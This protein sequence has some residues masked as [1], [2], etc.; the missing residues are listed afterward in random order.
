MQKLNSSL[1]MYLPP[2]RCF[3]QFPYLLFLKRLDD[4]ENATKQ[5]VEGNGQFRA[6]GK[7]NLRAW[8]RGR[9]IEPVEVSSFCMCGAHRLE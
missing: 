6:G 5:D 4:R 9:R 3:E 1:H 8:W 2:F 7:K